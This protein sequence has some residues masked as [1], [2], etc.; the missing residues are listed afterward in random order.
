M[1][2]F[3]LAPT[4]Y[5]IYTAILL[6]LSFNNINSSHGVKVRFRYDGNLFDLRR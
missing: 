3:K 5:G 4:L 1:Q 2:G 6:Q